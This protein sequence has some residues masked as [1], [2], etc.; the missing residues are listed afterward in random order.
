MKARD[1]SPT[2]TIKHIQQNPPDDLILLTQHACHTSMA[3]Y[4]NYIVH[5]GMKESSSY[6]QSQ[7]KIACL[8]F[9]VRTYEMRN[10]DMAT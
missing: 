3:W 9:V 8:S 6:C 1:V 5:V 4:V 2:K 10:I 7:S